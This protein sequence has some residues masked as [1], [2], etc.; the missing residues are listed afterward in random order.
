MQANKAVPRLT[1]TAR[2]SISRLPARLETTGRQDPMLV[3]ARAIELDR[4]ERP[5]VAYPPH[6]SSPWISKELAT[7][8]ALLTSRG[9]QLV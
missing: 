3:T 8:Y 7:L 4:G 9:G 1:K 2:R 6:A 5:S